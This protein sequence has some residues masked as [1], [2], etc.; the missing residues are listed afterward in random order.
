MT[1]IRVLEPDRVSFRPSLT[2]VTVNEAYRPRETT[3][4]LV[5]GGK[6]RPIAI[7]EPR[8]DGRCD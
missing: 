5:P 3:P 6:D 7:S 8:A 2:G 1:R 4:N